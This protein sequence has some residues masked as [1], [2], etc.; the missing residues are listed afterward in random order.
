MASLTRI[1]RRISLAWLLFVIAPQLQLD[2]RSNEVGD[3]E[4]L[5]ESATCPGGVIKICSGVGTLC[6]FATAGCIDFQN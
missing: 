1:F 3:T 4:E 2:A 5:K 6:D